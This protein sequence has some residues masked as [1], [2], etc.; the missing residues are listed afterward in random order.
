MIPAGYHEN[1]FLEQAPVK[2]LAV[3]LTGIQACAR[4]RLAQAAPYSSKAMAWT[5][6]IHI[7]GREEL[8]FN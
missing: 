4:L 2:P 1:F 6:T 7:N 8:G 5:F 3:G